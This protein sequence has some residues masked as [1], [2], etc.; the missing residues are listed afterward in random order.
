MSDSKVFS[1]DQI[2]MSIMVGAFI[3]AHKQADHYSTGH[4]TEGRV[5]LQVMTGDR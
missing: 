4:T 3:S 1:L 5:S 2:M